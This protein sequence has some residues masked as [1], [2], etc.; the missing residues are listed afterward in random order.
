MVWLNKHVYV[1]SVI[2]TK[3]SR[4]VQIAK[5]I[6]SAAADQLAMTAAL[7]IVLSVSSDSLFF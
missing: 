6:V 7:T 1:K 3:L 5:V 2:S 4:Q